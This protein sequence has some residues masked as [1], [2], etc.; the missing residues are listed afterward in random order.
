VSAG[1]LYLR[2]ALVTFSIETSWIIAIAHFVRW[3]VN[4]TYRR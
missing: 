4:P 2:H 1:F 3:T